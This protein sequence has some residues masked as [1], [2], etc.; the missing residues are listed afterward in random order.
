MKVV[1]LQKLLQADGYIIESVSCSDESVLVKM[2]R[3]A[4]RRLPC[5]S[6]KKSMTSNKS[7]P[8]F[9][10]DAP[11]LGASLTTLQYDAIQGKCKHCGATA[12]FHPPCV[13]SKAKATTR[14]KQYVSRLCRFMP[15]SHVPEFIAISHETAR[16]YDKEVLKEAIGE[17]CLDGLRYL[18]VDEKAIGKRHQYVTIVL[19]AETGELLHMAEG[20][21]KASLMEFYETLSTK[22]RASIVA[23]CTDRS[24]AYVEA[25]REALPQAEIVYDKFHLIQNLN[26]AIDTLRRQEMAKANQDEKRVLKGQRYNILRNWET[27]RRKASDALDAALAINQPLFTGHVLKEQFRWA[28][29]YVYPNSARKYLEYWCGMAEESELRPLVDFARG[30]RR[31]L[32]GV[33]AFF[34]H[35]LTNGPIEAFNSIIGR[36]IYRACGV[37]DLDYLFLKLRQE[38][39]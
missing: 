36:T 8:R 37:K 15:A 20:K 9:A 7:T 22:Q 19:N 33:V 29:T 30:L 34:R 1:G 14:L 28:W 21:K 26:K 24:G 25:T 35:K 23:V 5:P 27:L 17:P 11:I 2:R 12:T 10:Q 16:R 32:G 6:C 38:S 3:D 13:E 39:L 4:R 31:D 18:Q